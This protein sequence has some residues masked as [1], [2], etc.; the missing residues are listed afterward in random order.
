LETLGDEPGEVGEASIVAPVPGGIQEVSVGVHAVCVL[1]QNGLVYYFGS[2]FTS[3]LVT[4]ERNL[5]DDPN[6]IGANARPIDLPE[7]AS[8]VSCGSGT[9]CALDNQGH[10]NCWG[11]CSFGK[12]GIG[13][14]GVRGDQPNEMGR[15]LP[16]VEIP[17]PVVEVV[18]GNHHA[19]AR[20]GDGRVKCW[21]RNDIGELGI[22]HALHVGDDAGEMEELPFVDLGRGI[23]AIDIAAAGRTTC[24]VIPGGLIK[25]WGANTS[26]QLGQGDLVNRGARVFDLEDSEPISVGEAVAVE[27]GTSHVCALLEGGSVKCWGRGIRGI[28][29]NGMPDDL[30]GDAAGEVGLNLPAVDLGG[31]AV[32]LRAGGSH[33]CALL[34]TG[35]VKCWGANDSGQLGIGHV[36]DVGDDLVEMGEALQPTPV[37]QVSSTFE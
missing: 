12:C 15:F 32:A 6:E 9:Q 24:A 11:S 10:L 36:E 5:G 33:T 8:S 34:A 22:G 2:G 21:G 19:C 16:F 1:N 35:V 30:V 17:A 28:L 13:E 31:P 27:V 29:G 25:C 37:P 4:E 3:G 23:E 14:S 18:H 26:G 20:F 7:R